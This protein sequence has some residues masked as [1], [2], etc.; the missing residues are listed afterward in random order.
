M[1]LFSSPEAG[2]TLRP[3][4]VG[5]PARKQ[6]FSSPHVLFV[7]VLPPFGDD[8]PLHGRGPF[9]LLSTDL[10]RSTLGANFEVLF[11]NAVTAAG[12]GA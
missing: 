2:E 9:N 3:G 6:G 10:V 7:V 5:G 8:Q 12:D 11:Q 4:K 1:I